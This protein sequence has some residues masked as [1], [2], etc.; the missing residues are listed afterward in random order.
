MLIMALLVAVSLPR[1][2]MVSQRAELN[3]QTATIGKQLFNLAHWPVLMAWQTY[4]ESLA[5]Q[6]SSPGNILGSNAYIVSDYAEIEISITSKTNNTLKYSLLV[7]REHRLSGEFAI[8]QTKSRSEIS[9]T[10]QGTIHSPIIGG[11]IVLYIHSLVDNMFTVSIN[12]L[13]TQLKLAH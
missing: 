1:Q 9:H 6:S 3:Y 10:L 13:D 8:K 4:G 12:N 2:L 5:V 11:F 7:N